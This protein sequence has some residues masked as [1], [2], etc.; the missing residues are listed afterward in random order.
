MNF[1]HNE[2]RTYVTKLF[3]YTKSIIFK[4]LVI[5]SIIVLAVPPTTIDGLTYSNE[6]VGTGAVVKHGDTGQKCISVELKKFL[7][8]G[9]RQFAY[10]ANLIIGSAINI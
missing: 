10:H 4:L 2:R 5:F 9:S 7:N 1:T 6:V 8:A 3:S